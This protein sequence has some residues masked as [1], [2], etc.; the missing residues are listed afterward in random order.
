MVNG[1]PKRG[2]LKSIAHQLR[3]ERITISQQYTRMRFMHL[4]NNQDE[5]D[6]MEIINTSYD[7]F[8]GTQDIGGFGNLPIQEIVRCSGPDR[9]RGD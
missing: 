9:L 2:I 3:F 6:H 8:F 1:R 7:S 5:A 4:L